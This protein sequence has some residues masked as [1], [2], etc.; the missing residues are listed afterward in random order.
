M[1]GETGQRIPSGMVPVLLILSQ[2][3]LSPTRVLTMTTPDGEAS[4]FVTL[5]ASGRVRMFQP[6]A[7]S[8]WLLEKSERLVLT[9]GTSRVSVYDD[10]TKHWSEREYVV[11]RER[12]VSALKRST[13]RACI[14]L[15]TRQTMQKPELAPPYC[16]A[17]WTTDGEHELE[18]PLGEACKVTID[19]I[20]RVAV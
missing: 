13:P 11:R 14:A 16:E 3:S 4:C 15:E 6:H 19:G 7:A 18:V 20:S 17:K 2:L 9:E 1:H 10:A 5:P 8:V 12:Q